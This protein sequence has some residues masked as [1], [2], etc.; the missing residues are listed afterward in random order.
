MSLNNNQIFSA[1]PNIDSAGEL[2][3]LNALTVSE[4]EFKREFVDRS[5]ACLIKGA[6]SQWSAV[7][8]WKSQDFWLNETS[9]F[10]VGTFT[11][12][13][14]NDLEWMQENVEIMGFHSAI[15]R[16]FSDDDNIFSIPTVELTKIEGLANAV[17]S[18]GTFGF[19][20]DPTRPRAYPKARAFMYKGAA[21]GWHFHDFD[22]TLMCQVV[23]TK[24]VALLSPDIENARE[25][26]EFFNKDKYIHGE[27]LDASF[28][29]SPLVATVEQ[30]DALYIP[31]YWYH[32][33]APKDNSIGF[34][35]AYCWGSPLHR[36]GDFSNFFVR[37]AYK[38][39]LY[40]ITP[41]SIL[42]PIIGLIAAASFGFNKRFRQL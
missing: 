30:G 25:I 7:S 22:E 41:F 6:V 24:Q 4:K 36:L 34:T 38:N 2:P 39:I 28:N 40:P 9:D 42:S 27:K 33:V 21:T 19:L 31:P 23:G 26:V 20:P 16:L 35:L 18:L 5:Q 13:N 14:Y 3:I 10:E 17:D 32:G 12:H 11:N 15:Q 29:L 8:K 37:Y 1:I